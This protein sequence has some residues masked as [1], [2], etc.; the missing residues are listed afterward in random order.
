[1]DQ[2]ASLSDQ[3]TYVLVNGLRMYYES[4]GEGIPV[5]LLHGGLETCGMWAPVV[6]ELSRSYRV[7]T[8]DS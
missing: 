6:A 3:G 2:S 4:H 1:M 5:I 7:V 8:P